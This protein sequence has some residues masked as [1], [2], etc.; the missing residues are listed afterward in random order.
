M[1]QPSA[2]L[3]LKTNDQN[4]IRAFLAKNKAPADYVVPSGLQNAGVMGCTVFVWQGSEV[5][6]IAFQSGPPPG[7][8]NQSD[9]WFFV[10]ERKAVADAPA[11]GNLDFERVEQE[12]TASWSDDTHTYVLAAAGDEAMLKKYVP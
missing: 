8:G 3:T 4:K 1:A 2:T 6:M 12:L 5:S 9:L 7:P 10:A 11:A